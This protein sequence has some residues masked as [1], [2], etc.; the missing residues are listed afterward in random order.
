MHRDLKPENLLL[1]KDGAIKIADLGCARS[2]GVAVRL[3]GEEVVTRHYR[4]PEI[5][6]GSTQYGAPVDIWSVGAIM[7]EMVTG[8]VLFPG[9]SDPDQLA[10]ICG[11]L[12][13][14][15]E[16]TWPGVT[17]LPR[18]PSVPQA[19]APGSGLEARL[20]GGCDPD[21]VELVTR[22]LVLCPDTRATATTAL[23]HATFAHMDNTLLSSS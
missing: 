4:A 12:G 1:A 10:R 16:L 18:Y 13:P 11:V 19:A 17:Q 9:E 6:L 20:G 7:A 15:S 22:L 8:E 23:E 21:M 2:F 14:P 3:Q 5:L